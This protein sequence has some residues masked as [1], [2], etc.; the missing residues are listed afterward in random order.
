MLG[1]C[2]V[3]TTP[4]GCNAVFNRTGQMFDEAFSVARMLGVKTCIGTESPLTIPGAVKE[5][6]LAQHKDPSDPAVVRELYAG[7]FKRIAAAHPLDY[8]WVWTP[9]RWL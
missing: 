7:I 2:P 4:E 8:Y 6:L 1:Q 9:E 5:R 3:P